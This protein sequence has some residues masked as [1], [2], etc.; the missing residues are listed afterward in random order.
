MIPSAAPS[1]RFV[2]INDWPFLEQDG[3]HG[4]APLI[5]RTIA[6]HAGPMLLLTDPQ[7]LDRVRAMAL[8]FEVRLLDDCATLTTNLT[9]EK[10]L[11]CKLERANIR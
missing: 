7:E 2:R 5:R 3:Q 1:I 10:F 6:D 9:A 8:L 11:L 4:F